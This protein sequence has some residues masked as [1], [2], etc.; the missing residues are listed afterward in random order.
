VQKRGGE[1]KGQVPFRSGAT[2]A[3]V[4]MNMWKQHTHT[5]GVGESLKGQNSPTKPKPK[6]TLTQPTTSKRTPC[7]FLE[8]RCT[9]CRVVG[10][11][12]FG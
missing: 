12:R 11:F 2:S 9:G 6:V 7:L 5:R 8:L 10:L 4:V 1:E 3:K